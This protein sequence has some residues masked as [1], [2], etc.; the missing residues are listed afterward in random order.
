MI[1]KLNII[2]VLFFAL[3]MNVFAQEKLS[4]LE[5]IQKIYDRP[6][7]EDQEGL[8]TMTLINSRGDQRVR[9]IKQYLKDFGKEEKKIMFLFPPLMYAIRHS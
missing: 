7:G 4:G 5:I 6:T 2:T 3:S 1:Y 9:E 8:L